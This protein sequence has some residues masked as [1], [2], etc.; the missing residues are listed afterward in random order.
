M[1]EFPAYRLAGMQLGNLLFRDVLAVA[2]TEE[3]FYSQMMSGPKESNKEVVAQAKGAIGRPLLERKNLLFDV[4]QGVLVSCSK[5]TAL[6]KLGYALDGFAK[7]P[8]SK[9]QVYPI[10]TAHT[11]IGQVRLAIDTGCTFS[12]LRMSRVG[13]EWREEA[14]NG[15]T[16]PVFFSQHLKIGT[17]DFGGLEFDLVDVTPELTEIDGILGMDFVK[18]HLV[19]IDQQEQAVYIK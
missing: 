9:G 19:Y 8:F 4:T 6:K 16:F 14:E 10:I 12:H 5:K 1:W 2:K 11:E 18:D 3:C 7:V 15:H 13:K 17:R